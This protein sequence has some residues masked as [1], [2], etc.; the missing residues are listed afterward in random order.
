MKSRIISSITE[1]EICPCLHAGVDVFVRHFGKDS[2]QT[3]KPL[4][5]SQLVTD[6]GAEGRQLSDNC[7]L[8]LRV[9]FYLNDIP[10]LKIF[11]AAVLGSSFMNLMVR[12]YL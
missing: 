10:L 5:N 7:F 11:P 3:K 12:G 9:H 8:R 1:F 4:L 2:F 6:P